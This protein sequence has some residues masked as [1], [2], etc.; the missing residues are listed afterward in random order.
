MRQ[1][2]HHSRKR[3]SS[4]SDGALLSR[5]LSPQPMEGLENFSVATMAAGWEHTLA[6]TRCG[7]LFSF[8]G[9]YRYGGDSAEAS[10]VVGVAAAAGEMGGVLGKR[11]GGGGAS[12]TRVC[13]DALESARVKSIACGWDHCMAVTDDGALF[14]WGSGR[15]G[16]LGHGDTGATNVLCRTRARSCWNMIDNQEKSSNI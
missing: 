2:N 3:T 6:L 14:T 13:H 5:K 11:G 16:Q 15:A 7:A 4:L 8:G 10:A 1:N 12:P 9:G